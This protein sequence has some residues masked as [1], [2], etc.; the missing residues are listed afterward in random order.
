MPHLGVAAYGRRALFRGAFLLLIAAT[1]ALAAVLLGGEKERSYAAYR[2]SLAGTAAQLAA[3]LRHPAGQLALLNPNMGDPAV[4]PLRP[5]LLPFGAID[6]DDPNKARQAVETAGCSIQYADG[7]SICIAVGSNPYAGGFIYI[8]GSFLSGAL[9][10]STVS[11]TRAPGGTDLSTSHRA[12]VSL[13]LRGERMRWIAPF[14]A[15]SAPGMALRGRLTGFVEPESPELLPANARAV[16][17]FR[18]WLWQDAACASTHSG[19]CLQR[20]FFSIRLPVEAY[21]DALF[22]KPRPAWPPADLDR[23]EVRFEMLAPGKGVVLFDSNAAGAT[24]PASLSELAA[25]L[26]PGESLAVRS[27]AVAKPFL[28]LRARAADVEVSAPWIEAVLRRLPPSGQAEAPLQEFTVR[29]AVGD[30]VAELRGDFRAVD[31]ALS[32]TATRMSWF[33]VAMLGAIALAWLVIEIGLIRR[34]AEL[35]RRAS[36]LS[37]TLQSGDA[38]TL[39]AKLDVADLRGRD[40]LGLLAG[41]LDDLLKRV[42]EDVRREQIRARQERDLWHAVGHEIMSPL[43][44]LLALHPAAGDPSR[45]YVE[46]MQQAVR[47]LY[48]T[49]SPGE[50]I[51]A[52]TLVAGRLDLDAFLRNVADNATYAGIAAVS[53]VSG[54]SNV[55]VRADEFPLEDAVAHVLRNADRFRFAGTAIELTLELGATTA[56]IA[57][58]NRGPLIDPAAL[59]R[60]FEYGVS[61]EA[62]AGSIETGTDRIAGSAN[63]AGHRG[64]GL[65]VAKTYL[66]KMGGTITAENVEGGVTFRMTLQRI[67]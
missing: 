39:A 5:L 1:L 66:A 34:I 63:A 17:D 45:R 24:A 11:S 46:R 54:G 60:I 33:V 35:T 28:N 61:G 55:P 15:Q 44:S 9:T 47:V 21:R 65:F 38:D 12:R 29:T 19:D 50:A 52:A 40:E 27:A 48:G 18:G 16:R 31:R 32:V 51:E 2:Q 58:H 10:P 3:R 59:E 67:T 25:L 49:A 23:T 42:R 13:A 26:E 14:E 8:V 56:V 30:F 7:G 6:F 64:Q 53:Y 62:G 36:A 20:S 37:Q 22:Q 41:G 57:I 4:I 43:Q